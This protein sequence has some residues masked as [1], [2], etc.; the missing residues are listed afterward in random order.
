[1]PVCPG[2][3]CVEITAKTINEYDPGARTGQPFT[4]DRTKN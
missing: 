3:Y 1:M 2:K 4:D